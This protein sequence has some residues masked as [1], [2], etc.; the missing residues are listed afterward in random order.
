YN[1]ERFTFNT[2]YFFRRTSN[3]IDW[4]KDDAADKTWEAGNFGR[5]D[6]QGYTLNGNY[7]LSAK[8]GAVRFKQAGLS[9]TYLNPN[10]SN[11]A[12]AGKI[13]KYAVESLRHQLAATTDLQLFSGFSLTAGARYC[14]RIN[15][16]DYTLIDARLG[17]TGR[18]F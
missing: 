3:F 17:Y 4:V 12:I 5:R 18:T 1:D 16:K 10:I 7:R 15:Y 2:S 6:I 14:K 13:S 9:Y 8:P 11:S